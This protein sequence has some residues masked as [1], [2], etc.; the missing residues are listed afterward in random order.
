MVLI[1]NSTEQI[2]IEGVSVVV[3]HY[4]LAHLDLS[5]LLLLLDSV[6]HSGASGRG[7][8]DFDALIDSD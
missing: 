5:F 2:V 8:Q 3:I 6:G 4:Y 1:F 7:P